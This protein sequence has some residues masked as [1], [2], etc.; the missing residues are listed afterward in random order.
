MS[1]QAAKGEAVFE[2][3]DVVIPVVDSKIGEHD[4]LVAALRV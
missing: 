1:T 3:L 2:A 4:V